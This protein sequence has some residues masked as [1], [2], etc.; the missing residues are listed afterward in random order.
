MTFLLIAWGLY[1]GL[2]PAPSPAPA[3]E[4]DPGPE[5]VEPVNRPKSDEED[6]M[7]LRLRQALDRAFAVG[8]KVVPVHLVTEPVCRGIRRRSA[9]HV[10]VTLA[11]ISIAAP[12]PE[13]AADVHAFVLEQFEPAARKLAV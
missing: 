9:E 11:P 2:Q 12:R 1:L 10:P 3:A 7:K 5:W 8:P 13:T 4:P 6:A